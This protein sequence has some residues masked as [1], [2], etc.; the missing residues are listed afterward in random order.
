[1]RYY[2]KTH[3]LKERTGEGRGATG[4]EGEEEEDSARGIALL[5][6]NL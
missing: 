2:E 3:S 4:G 6:E 5:V 1:M